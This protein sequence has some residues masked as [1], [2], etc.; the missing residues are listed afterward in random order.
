MSVQ[1]IQYACPDVA[2]PD[3]KRRMRLLLAGAI[4]VP[5]LAAAVLLDFRHDSIEI[6]AI[7]GSR[8]VRSSWPFG[9]LTGGQV[10][11]SALE[12]RLNA[13]GATWT[14]DWRVLTVKSYSAVGLNVSRGCG[15]SPPIYSAFAAMPAF[16]QSAT[17]EEVRELVDVLQ[18]GSATEQHDA[19]NEAIDI[20]FR[21]HAADD[22]ALATGGSTSPPP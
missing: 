19:L 22:A 2:R 3:W 16:A 18:N 7:T 14:P 15:L 8:R 10:K 11:A 5:T 12:Q 17:D 9:I 13:M 20:A 6:D 1:P 21:P 4:C